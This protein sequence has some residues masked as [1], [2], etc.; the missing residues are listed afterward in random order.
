MANERLRQQ[1]QEALDAA[2]STEEFQVLRQELDADDR[3]SAE[4]NRLKKVDVMLKSAP[5]EHAPE[6]LALNIIARL[7]EAMKPENMTRT[8]GLALALGLA[9]VML[10]ALPLLVAALGLFM[11]AMGNPEMLSRVLAQIVNLLALVVSMLEVFA[12]SA[13][14]VLNNSQAPALLLALIPI[15]TYWLLRFVQNQQE[16]E[17]KRQ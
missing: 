11:T 3:S 13:Q 6:R 4:Y 14:E 16:D 9:L 1:M 2:L 10:V 17:G 7:A 5:F 8:S 15:T 12:Q